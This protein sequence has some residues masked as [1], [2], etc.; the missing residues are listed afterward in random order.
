MSVAEIPVDQRVIDIDSRRFASLE[1]ALVELITNSDDS[2]LRLGQEGGA[3][4][5]QYERHLSGAVLKVTDQA[6]GMS[7][8]Q[9]RRILSY[10][11]AHSVLAN[12]GGSGRGYFGRGLKQA[13]FGLGYGWIETIRDGRYARIELFRGENGGYLFDDGAGDRAVEAADRE[14]LGIPVN[15]TRVTIVV[16]NPQ[17]SIAQFQSLR[18]ALA[19]NIYLREVLARR[20]V[21]LQE[22]HDGRADGAPLLVRHEEPPATVLLGPELAAHFEFGG[23][24]YP[25]TLTLKRALGAELTLRGDE[26]TN[27]LLVVSGEAVLDCQLFE[28]ENKVGTEYLFGTVRCPALLERLAQGEAI[29]SDEREGLNLRNPFVAAFAQAV[30]ALIA[31][32]VQAELDR[33]RHL[34]HATTSGRTSQMIEHLLLHMSEVAIHDLGITLGPDEGPVQ[35]AGAAEAR[36]AL[37]FS[38]PFYYR[39]PGHPFHVTLIVDPARLGPDAVLNISYALPE[40]VRIEPAVSE[41]PV[42][43]LAGA[44]TLTWTVEGAQAGARGT[45]TVTAGLYLALCEIVLAEQAPRHPH[46]RGRAVHRGHR[47]PQHDHGVILFAG[48]E[49]RALDNEVDRA[50]YS[51]VE[52]KVI[53]NTRAPTVQLYLDGRGRF[54]DAARLL[55]AELFLDVIADELARRVVARGGQPWSE[56]AHQAAKREII[57]RY[58]GDVHRAFLGG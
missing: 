32:A 1:K 19:D 45:I 3:I 14:R 27:G 42:S 33:L 11:G 57:H 21:M 9:A 24:V 50:I 56:A 55:L 34:D 37:R 49:L 13:V 5:V 41:R 52:R 58:G 15:G 35:A 48:Y 6:E 4:L 54:R 7:H 22:M 53:I 12:G 43:E 29:I 8:A 38:T 44:H 31:P 10:G 40:S 36:E 46:P 20:E 16:D 23:Q 47:R 51:P 25:F 30:S 18:H 39:P 17:V 26:R 2:Y 28:F